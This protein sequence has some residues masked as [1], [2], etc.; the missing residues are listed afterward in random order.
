MESPDFPE[1]VE[2]IGCISM[3]GF[4]CLSILL[5]LFIAFAAGFGMACMWK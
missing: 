5:A 2:V 3:A 1:R 4:G